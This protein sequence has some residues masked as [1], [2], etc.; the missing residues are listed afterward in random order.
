MR[1]L[2]VSKD[3][4]CRVAKDVAEKYGRRTLKPGKDRLIQMFIK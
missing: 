4:I 3:G 1:I 2:W